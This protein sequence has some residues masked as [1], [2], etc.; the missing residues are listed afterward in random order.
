MNKLV[1]IGNGFD[2]AH[3]LKTSYTNF[4]E[5]LFINEKYKMLDTL[6]SNKKSIRR[7]FN[8]SSDLFSCSIEGEYIDFIIKE[9]T[10]IN[11][12][13]DLINYINSVAKKPFIYDNLMYHSGGK[14]LA[15]R[16][17]L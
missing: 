10:N 4:L 15:F 12:V 11:T 6:E 9:I 7:G 5:Y 2:L 16:R 1:I 8:F 13:Q 3:G 17:R 14:S